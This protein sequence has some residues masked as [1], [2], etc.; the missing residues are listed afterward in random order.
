MT[1]YTRDDVEGRTSL[2]IEIWADPATRERVVAALQA[3]VVVRNM[4]MRFRRENGDVGIGLISGRLIDVNGEPCFLSITRD[5]T[6][7]QLAH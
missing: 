6:D 3:H 5:I 1:G 2:E 7:R 4:E